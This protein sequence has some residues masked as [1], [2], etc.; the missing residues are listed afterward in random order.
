MSCGI[1]LSAQTA[2]ASALG[3]SRKTNREESSITEYND[4]VRPGEEFGVGGKGGGEL[5]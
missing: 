5:G 2:A 1:L 3:F 4:Y